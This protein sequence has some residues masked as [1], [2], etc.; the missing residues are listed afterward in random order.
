MECIDVNVYNGTGFSR[1]LQESCKGFKVQERRFC[2]DIKKGLAVRE[3]QQSRAL[4]KAALASHFLL[5]QKV[6]LNDPWESFHSLQF[7]GSLY[8]RTCLVMYTAAQEPAD[9]SAD[10][11]VARF[12]YLNQGGFE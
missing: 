11:L 9:P 2:L 4:V 7:Y 5:Q 8:I 1:T 12:K 6:G 10:P 3:V